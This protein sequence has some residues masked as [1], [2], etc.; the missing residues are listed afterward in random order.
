MSRPST[1]IEPGRERVPELDGIRG[2]AILMVLVW[3]YVVCQVRVPPG[4]ISGSL[5]RVFNLTWS[6]VDLFFVLSGLLIGGILLDNRDSPSYF[7]T[8]YARRACRILPLYYAFVVLFALTLWL[9]PGRPHSRWAWLVYGPLPLWS[10]ATFTQNLAMALR[11]TF[12]SN[13]AAPTWSLAIEEQ[14][15]LVLPLLVRLAPRRRLE[16]VLGALICAAIPVRVFLHAL[17]GGSWTVNYVLLPSRMDALLIGVVLACI[18][19]T[20]AVAW[21]QRRR[22]WVT[23]ALVL[24]GTLVWP[25][26][27]IPVEGLALWGYTA[28]ALFYATLVLRVRLGAQEWWGAVFR[29]R[30]L[31]HLG[32]ISYGLY[33]F[34]QV[35]SGA[36]HA[37]VF[38]RGPQITSLPEAAVTGVALV[39]TLGLCNLSWRYFERPLVEWGRRFRY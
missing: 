22:R 6:G 30:V 14:F 27:S 19:R 25:L 38:R 35:V 23:V 28:L 36:L 31:V 7:R 9:L 33:L 13:F 12:G 32:A 26:L 3:H 39:L 37:V 1:Q 20:P 4:G 16:W 8:F 10:Y 17:S 5:L 2:L 15:Y 24:E 18:L 34:H 29:G 11:D 21:L